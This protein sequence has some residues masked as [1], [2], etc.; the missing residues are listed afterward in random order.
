MVV[1]T[2]TGAAAAYRA[3]AHIA[4]GMLTDRLP[5]P[6][7]RLCA[8][9]VDIAMAVISAFGV[10][11]GALLS[12]GT[13][14]QTLGE[15]PWMPVGVTYLPLPIGAGLTLLFVLEKMC[16]GSQHERAVVTFDHNLEEAAPAA[17]KG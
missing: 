12:I 13:M 8:M 10:Y 7:R 2:F 1:F 14:G 6:L 4:V 15:L 3:G 11:Y 17:A 16:F 9:L 5:V